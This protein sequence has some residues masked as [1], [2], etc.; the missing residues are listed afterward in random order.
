MGLATTF[1]F[2][3]PG[4][5]T[6]TD[7]SNLRIKYDGTLTLSTGTACNSMQYGSMLDRNQ[8]SQ[9]TGG[10]SYR[11]GQPVR[12]GEQRRSVRK[13]HWFDSAA[14]YLTQTGAATTP[15]QAILDY[16]G[17]TAI[18]YNRTAASGFVKIPLLTDVLNSSNVRN[19]KAFDYNLVFKYRNSDGLYVLDDSN[20][21]ISTNFT[22]FPDLVTNSD[23]RTVMFPTL[24]VIYSDIVLTGTQVLPIS[25]ARP[26]R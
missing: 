11:N 8:R 7:L 6:F 19:G 22:H 1:S 2:S 13:H 21:G 10:C 23:V 17:K 18:N 4:K 5:Y 3:I 15:P 14:S 12:A 25:G 26:T 24:S 20:G 9:Y 16:L